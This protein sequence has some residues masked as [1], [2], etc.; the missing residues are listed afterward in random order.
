LKVATIVGHRLGGKFRVAGE[1][2]VAT[3]QEFSNLGTE[4]TTDMCNQWLPLPG[5][6]AFI[7]ISHS[8]S[9]ASGQDQSGYVVS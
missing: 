8:A 1:I 7:P 2:A 5:Y 4:A 9:S 3:D 6:Q